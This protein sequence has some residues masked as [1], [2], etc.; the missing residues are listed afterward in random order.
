MTRSQARTYASQLVACGA[1]RIEILRLT[2]GSDLYSIF[3]SFTPPEQRDGPFLFQ[4]VEQVQ[5]WI[6]SEES[7]RA[8]KETI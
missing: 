2:A 8:Q 3:A 1:T 6:A 4:S 5:R 7:A